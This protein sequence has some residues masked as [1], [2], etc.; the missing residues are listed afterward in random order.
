M[1]NSD[2]AFMRQKVPIDALTDQLVVIFRTICIYS[3]TFQDSDGF[4]WSD[5]WYAPYRRWRE[6]ASNR[7]PSGDG[8]WCVTMGTNGLWAPTNCDDELPSVCEF[9]FGK[10]FPSDGSRISRGGGA[11]IRGWC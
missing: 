10:V 5:G 7:A 6:G 8:L 3:L 1:I 4:V 2:T 11:L 9:S